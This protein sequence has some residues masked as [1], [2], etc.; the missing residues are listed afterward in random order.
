MGTSIVTIRHMPEEFEQAADT[1]AASEE[2]H[3]SKSR[4]RDRTSVALLV[5]AVLAVLAVALSGWSLF[6]SMQD[7]SDSA[8]N[9][10]ESERAA[11][12]TRVCSAFETVRRGVSRN[13]SLAPPGGAGDVTGSLAVAA[14]ARLALY[15]G[16]LYLLAK[17]EPATPTELAD[18]VEGFANDLMDIASAATAGAQDGDPDQVERLKKADE[19][20]SRIGELCA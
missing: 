11:A 10:S 15:N 20:N 4:V 19:A 9:S 8:S 14:N 5:V 12:K 18:T 16:G 3:R 13:T 6:Q 7:E 1:A 2:T 17:L